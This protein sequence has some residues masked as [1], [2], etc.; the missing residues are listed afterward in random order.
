MVCHI[1]CVI[2]V[3]LSMCYQDVVV[4]EADNQIVSI[5]ADSV[6]KVW[7]MRSTR[8]LQTVVERTDFL[9][10]RCNLYY[11]NQKNVREKQYVCR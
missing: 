9:P 5:G 3:G 10:T 6:I 7:D 4:N 8:C 2:V 11:D 1:I